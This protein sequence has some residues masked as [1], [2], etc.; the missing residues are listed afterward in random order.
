MVSKETAEHYQWGRDCDGWHLLKSRNLSVIL[1][2]MPRGASEVRHYHS[3]ARQFF[4]MLAG[5]ATLEIAG[6]R[7][8]LEW[9]QGV[10]IPPGIPHQI[11]NESGEEIE[12]IVVSHPPSHGDRVS[13]DLP[14]SEV[15]NL[16][17]ARVSPSSENGVEIRT[18]DIDDAPCIES[19]LHESF[20]EYEPQ[21]TKEGFAATALAKDQIEVRMSEGPSWIAL[22]D[23]KI[24]GTVSAVPKGDSL[25]IRGMAVLPSARGQKVGELLLKHV[26]S[27]ASERGYQALT[28]STTPFLNR[29]I[30]L[31]EHY[32]FTRCNG[33]PSD[34]FGTPLFTMTKKLE[35]CRN[36]N[37]QPSKRNA[38]TISA[39]RQ[40]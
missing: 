22:R 21:Y 26:E 6:S 36:S 5:T 35:R 18:A 30:R 31:Y 12:F 7:E 19:I 13:V 16:V 3:K 14:S 11:F 38:S 32:G 23:G 24:V 40:L 17:L 27:F 9:H 8:I 10:E 34:L 28:L 39:H 4:F 2:R 37:S 29:A 1:E 25:Y 33:G 15:G 20:V